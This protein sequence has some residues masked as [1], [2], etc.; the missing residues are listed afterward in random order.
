MGRGSASP[1]QASFRIADWLKEQ[2]KFGDYWE[3]SYFDLAESVGGVSM[4]AASGFLATR[5]RRGCVERTAIVDGRVRYRVDLHNSA[6][7]VVRRM[8]AKGGVV[9]RSSGH[10]RM[11]SAEIPFVTTRNLLAID[12]HVFL[13]HNKV[14]GTVWPSPVGR[15]P[16]DCWYKAAEWE[17]TQSAGAPVDWA[18]KMHANGWRALPFQLIAGV[19]HEPT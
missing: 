12:D 9:G 5:Y 18:K 7:F 16:Q 19:A 11:H 6:V 17:K 13:L 10:V 1:D 15:N 4:G 14:S 3:G 8:N 2:R